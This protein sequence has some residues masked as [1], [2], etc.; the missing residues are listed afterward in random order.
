MQGTQR[1]LSA[2]ARKPRLFS[3]NEDAYAVIAAQTVL[4]HFDGVSSGVA[5]VLS[6]VEDALVESHFV[7]A[8]LG[9]H[10]HLCQHLMVGREVDFA[11]I[12]WV[13]RAVEGDILIHGNEAHILNFKHIAAFLQLHGEVARRFGDA[14]RDEGGVGQGA[15][16]HR[17]IFHRQARRFVEHATFYGNGSEGI[18]KTAYKCQ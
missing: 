12:E 8:L 10:V 7:G 13:F 15:S 9:H 5:H 1:V 11:H 6:H 3:I 18:V 16:T 14:A 17:G 2:H 4:Q